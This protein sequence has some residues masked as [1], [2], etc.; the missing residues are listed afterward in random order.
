M[1][2]TQELA[3]NTGIILVHVLQ[4]TCRIKTEFV[5][6]AIQ[7]ELSAYVSVY[8]ESFDVV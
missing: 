3:A 7:V 8:S 2:I 4:S 5:K 1:F 6:V